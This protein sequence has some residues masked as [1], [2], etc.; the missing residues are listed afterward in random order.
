MSNFQFEREFA[1]HKLDEEKDESI[2][3]VQFP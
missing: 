3:G 1:I 2:I